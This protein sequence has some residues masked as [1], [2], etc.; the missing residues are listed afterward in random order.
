MTVWVALAWTVV[1]AVAG[2]WMYAQKEK[3]LAELL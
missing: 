3:E 2:I 1:A